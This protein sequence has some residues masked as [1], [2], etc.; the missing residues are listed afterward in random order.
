MV[1]CAWRQLTLRHSWQGETARDVVGR[2]MKTVGI[3]SEQLTEMMLSGR[4]LPAGRTLKTA[5]PGRGIMPNCTV[6]TP[7]PELFDK[8]MRE[9]IGVGTNLDNIGDPVPLMRRLGAIPPADPTGRRPGILCSLSWKH[10]KAVDFC[11][12]KLGAGAMGPLFNMNNS[13]LIREDEWSEFVG[14]KM[15]SVAVECAHACGDPGILIVRPGEEAT[16]TSP[17]GELWLTEKEVCNLGNMN[18]GKYLVKNKDGK[19]VLLEEMFRKEA[20]EALLFLDSVRGCLVFPVE[21]MKEAS[22]QKARTGLGVMGFAD[23]LTKLNI[24]YGEPASFAVARLFG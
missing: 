21:G 8:V 14:S 7:D 9:S 13:L 2:V 6:L 5:R 22:E 15:F 18:L 12:A 1:T 19:L 24:K 4:F 23:V 10:P 16:S 17:C 11:R 3:E 20:G